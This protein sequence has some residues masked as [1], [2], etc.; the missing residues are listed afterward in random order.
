[1]GI[2]TW[3]SISLMALWLGLALGCKQTSP[4][5]GEKVNQVKKATSDGPVAPTTNSNTCD[6]GTCCGKKGIYFRYRE[7]ISGDTV[8]I[9][10]NTVK[11]SKPIPTG[12]NQQWATIAET[13]T[14]TA[15]PVEETIQR[16]FGTANYNDPIKCKIWGRVYTAD[17]I[18]TLTG[19]DPLRYFAVDHIEVIK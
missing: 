11:F 7:T 12:T 8:I 14:L 6:D 17:K 2:F 1:M 4:L 5:E 3:R 15:A 18:S 16:V 19:M 10:G 9:R 13:C